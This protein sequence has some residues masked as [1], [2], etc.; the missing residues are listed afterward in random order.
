MT[1]QTVLEFLRAANIGLSLFVGLHLILTYRSA[2]WTAGRP[3]VPFYRLGTGFTIL[4]LAFG[5]VNGINQQRPPT[6]TVLFLSVGLIWLT[7]ATVMTIIDNRRR[8]AT[9]PA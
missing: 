1:M 3:H 9:P 5:A 6:L 8:K 7:V 4:V 2:E